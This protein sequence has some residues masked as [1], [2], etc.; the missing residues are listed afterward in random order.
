M[1]MD[2]ATRGRVYT[3]PA[4]VDPAASLR[5]RL[6][7]AEMERAAVESEIADRQASH[8]AAMLDLEQ[9]TAIHDEA[10]EAMATLNERYDG[11]V[12]ERD[13]IDERLAVVEDTVS[14]IS[15]ALAANPS[16]LLER[17]LAD[18][19]AERAD[20]IDRQARVFAN[21]DAVTEAYLAADAQR[22][23]AEGTI[24][25]IQAVIAS[26]AGTIE[27]LDQRRSELEAEIADLS[28]T[29]DRL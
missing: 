16:D 11:I 22:H 6:A 24:G 18:A 21:R 7:A 25:V 1:W 14:A 27:R 3:V 23:D 26:E 17:R 28:E 4:G 9:T 15:E 8:D 5:D 13:A 19:E 29:I 20:L 12:A 2:M 10:T